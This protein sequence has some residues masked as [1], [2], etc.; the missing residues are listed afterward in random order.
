VALAGI[1][2][3][4]GVGAAAVV[5]RLIASLLFDVRPVDAPTYAAVV[6]GLMLVAALASYL[7]ARR[8]SVVDPAESLAA[9]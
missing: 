4:I 9:E 6:A 8:A 1:G 7:P 3:A 5:T 2:I